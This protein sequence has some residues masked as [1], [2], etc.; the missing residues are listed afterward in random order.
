MRMMTGRK[1]A[2]EKIGAV[3]SMGS[4]D[5]KLLEVLEEG[6][7]SGQEYGVAMCISLLRMKLL[8]GTESNRIRAEAAD[9]LEETLNDIKEIMAHAERNKHQ[10]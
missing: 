3:S 5:K 1:W 7:N 9:R 4:M 6:F 8:D 2:L 10:D